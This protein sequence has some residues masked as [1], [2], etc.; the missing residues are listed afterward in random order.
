MAPM[1]STSVLAAF[2]G[3]AVLGCDVRV[4]PTPGTTAAPAS[5]GTLATPSAAATPP[6]PGSPIPTQPT[7][8]PTPT[9][10]GP[11]AASC[12]GRSSGATLVAYWESDDLWL[13]DAT[14]E[15]SRRLTD[16]G[17]TR[18]E[19][20]PS[21]VNA[22]CLVVAT[23]SVNG[24][25]TIELLD[26]S[27]PTSSRRLVEELGSIWS[28]AVRPDGTEMLYLH[29][30]HDL[31]STYR[32]KRVAVG[33]GP[34]EVVHTFAANL[35]RGGSSEDEVS[36]A[37]SPDGSTILVSNTHE[38]SK[39]FEQGGIYL[40]DPGTGEA[41]GHWAGTHPRWSPDGETVY[42]RGHGG[43]GEDVGWKTMDIES[44]RT[45]HLGMRPGTNLAAVSP[46]G[47]YIAYD[48]SSFG[49]MPTGA[50][51]TGEPPNV[52]LYDL[53]RDRETLL[54]R[55]SIATLWISATDMVVSNVSRGAPNPNTWGGNWWDPLG[56]VTKISV[57]GDH[58]AI[59]MRST[60][61]GAVFRGR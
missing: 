16:D 39:D 11:S 40:M 52:Y 1:R 27:A 10:T 13:Y 34:T 7:S 21:F 49:D 18:S 28:G 44:M 8:P 46:D 55:G 22:G 57:D 53:G 50:R 33:G 6:E 60:F 17:D 41:L 61:E 19:W 45:A 4:T 2:L 23:N 51:V 20:S 26:L 9:P 31:D 38:Y 59:D 29:I 30:D 42:F 36:L 37:W 24:G 56:T 32:L 12:A 43:A 47:R 54:R 5:A 48:T 14:A 58:R 35:G 25:A 15:K 3:L